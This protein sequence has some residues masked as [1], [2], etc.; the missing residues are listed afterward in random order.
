V[1]DNAMSEAQV[2]PLIPRSPCL[3]LITSR[4]QL[5][6]LEDNQPFRLGEMSPQDALVLLFRIG[7]DNSLRHGENLEATREV[8]TLCGRLPLALSIAGGHLRGRRA[9]EVAARL[10]DER[11]RLG[12]LQAGERNVK[13][14]FDLSY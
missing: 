2:R 5:D 12:E 9:R 4:G 11:R 1:L 3:V 8:A 6:Q 13:M 14:S 7:G 10:A